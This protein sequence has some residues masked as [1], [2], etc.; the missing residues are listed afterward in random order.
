VTGVAHDGGPRTVLLAG[1][2]G[3]SRVPGVSLGAGPLH[4]A[5]AAAAGVAAGAPPP[6]R[7]CAVAEESKSS[8]VWGRRLHAEAAARPVAL[9]LG[10]EHLVTFP[11][12]E[13]LAA[14]HPGLRVVVLDAH[15]DAYAYPLLTH[16]SVFH[17]V[18][19]EL[20]VPVLVVGARYEL[21]QADGVDVLGV[22]AC[23]TL[24]ADGVARRVR[25]HVGDAPLY[26]SVDLD[27][28]DPGLLPAVSAPVAGGLDVAELTALTGAL[29]ALAPV[30]VDVMEYNP[31]RDGPAGAGL[32]ALRPFFL[33]LARWLTCAPPRTS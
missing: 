15:H 2:D 4:A 13:A 32:A 1:Y 5:L 23:R 18:R 3:T 7:V 14:R 12:V 10:G 22:E 19:H 21:E 26:L 31:L 9:A 17:H 28:V 27:V 24:G 25:A 33:E 11:L 8:A 20:G 30:G 29:L 6:W 16:Y